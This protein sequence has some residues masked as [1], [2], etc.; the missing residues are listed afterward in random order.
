MLLGTSD[1]RRASSRMIVWAAIPSILLSFGW[2][3]L[4]A[5]AMA[6]DNHPD[7]LPVILIEFP[8]LSATIFLPI[9]GAAM[10]A[11][12][13]SPSTAESSEDGPS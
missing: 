4:S 13:P 8:A 9:L 2:C 3:A 1:M 12:R 10:A 6:A 5:F 7:E 11:G